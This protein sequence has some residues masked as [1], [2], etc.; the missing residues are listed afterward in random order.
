[1]WKRSNMKNSG[2]TLIEVLAATAIL[3]ISMA[4]LLSSMST[5]SIG[6][7]QLAR[8]SKVTR[9]IYNTADVYRLQP[10]NI[11]AGATVRPGSTL[12]V[13]WVASKQGNQ[14][15]IKDVFSGFTSP[16]DPFLELRS[17][18]AENLATSSYRKHILTFRY[19][20]ADLDFREKTVAVIVK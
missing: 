1:M 20:D 15:E 13:P 16:S 11:T 7:E 12:D 17:I 3:G 4:I 5:V 2:F 18:K 6:A 10:M 19:Q 9:A 14:W 8:G